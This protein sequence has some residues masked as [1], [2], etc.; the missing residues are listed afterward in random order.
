[1]EVPILLCLDLQN[2]F[3]D[4]SD[5]AP[6]HKDT[7]HVPMRLDYREALKLFNS[8]LHTHPCHLNA[9]ST[10]SVQLSV[11]PSPPQL[12]ITLQVFSADLVTHPLRSPLLK[13][14]LVYLGRDI[15]I[16]HHCTLQTPALQ[17]RVLR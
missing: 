2:R 12:E 11:H 10:R 7:K 16:L 14:I 4:A 6:H 9:A 3:G 5:D 15:E 1:M 13:N 8:T 17:S